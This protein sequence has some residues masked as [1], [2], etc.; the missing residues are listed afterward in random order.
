MKETTITICV[1]IGANQL[2]PEYIT[3]TVPKK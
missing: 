2:L 1:G 3:I